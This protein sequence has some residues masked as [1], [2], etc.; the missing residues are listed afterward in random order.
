VPP[1]SVFN[2]QADIPVPAIS[3]IEAQ[4]AYIHAMA[5][6]V[7]KLR[8]MLEEKEKIIVCPGIFDGITARIAL[9]TGFEC[10]YMVSHQCLNI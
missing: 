1:R 3:H 9:N 10:L 5:S 2:P 6:P 4:V 8:A 7:Q